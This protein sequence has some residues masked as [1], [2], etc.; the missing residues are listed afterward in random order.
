M[1]FDICRSRASEPFRF[2][3]YEGLV[4]PTG[5][6]AANLKELIDLVRTVPVEV[7]H[8]HLHRTPLSHRFGVWDYPNDFA[9]WAANSL[10]DL[11]LAEK[12][13]GLDPYVHSSLEAAREAILEL[14]EEHL[15]GLPM[16]PW[17][18]PGFEFHFA[19]GHFL[20]LPG[21]R[22]AWTLEE[23]R[24]ALSEV[25]L[26]SL[27]YHFHEAR[28]R[29]P[30]DESDDFSEWIEGQFGPHPVVS[31]LRGIDFFFF[32]LEDLRQRILLIFDEAR[33]GATR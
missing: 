8:H 2:V 27:Y 23:L 14:L 25:S 29:V 33:R 3:D 18:R 19:S 20:A 4:M 21:E 32:S 17:A 26:S 24:D 7:I 1:T 6:R 13:A 9:Q 16:V 12:L 15:D 10:E 11:A 31:A 30:G 5:L 28:L 22:V